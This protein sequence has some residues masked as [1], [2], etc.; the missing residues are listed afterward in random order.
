MT[1]DTRVEV[2]RGKNESSTALIRRFTRRAQGLGLVREMRDRRYFKR[3][4]SKNVGLKRALINKARRETY[5]ELVKL[6]KIDPAAKKVRK[7][8]RR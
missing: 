1:A 7:G 3:T 4:K 5:N 6:G 2:R 8:G